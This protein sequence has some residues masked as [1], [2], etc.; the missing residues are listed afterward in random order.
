MVLIGNKKS[1]LIG[2]ISQRGIGIA[3]QPKYARGLRMLGML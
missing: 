2:F 3:A 1:H